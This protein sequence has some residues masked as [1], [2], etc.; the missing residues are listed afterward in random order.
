M[1]LVEDNEDDVIITQRGFN[2]SN[3]PV[4]LHRVENGEECMQFLRKSG[5]YVDAPTP[6]LILLDLNM[7]VKDGREVLAEIVADEQLRRLAVVVLTTSESDQ[8]LLTMYDLRCSSYILKPVDFKQFQQVIKYIGE[9]WFT[10]VVL[11]NGTTHE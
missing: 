4:N 5:R 3:L 9:Y 10:I 8:D 1:L 7:P 2:K 11:P 6:D